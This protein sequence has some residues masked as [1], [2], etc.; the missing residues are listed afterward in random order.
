[1]SDF[2]SRVAS[3][4]VSQFADFFE[5]IQILRVDFRAF[6]RSPFVECL[7]NRFLDSVVL[8]NFH[9]EKSETHTE[10][11][12]RLNVESVFADESVNLRLDPRR[13][14]SAD[15]LR[16]LSNIVRR[17]PRSLRY[18]RKVS[19]ARRA[20]A[21]LSSSIVKIYFHFESSGL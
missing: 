17:A 16:L 10:T 15:P 1:M 20:A 8:E 11:V 2:Y 21:R 19:S 13:K 3:H 18:F 5:K 12:A 7:K 4:L 14:S 6:F 9:L